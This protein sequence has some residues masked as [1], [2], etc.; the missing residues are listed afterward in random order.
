MLCYTA[1][2]VLCGSLLAAWK[3]SSAHDDAA[4]SVASLAAVCLT[5]E[6][7]L[8]SCSND[9]VRYYHVCFPDARKAPAQEELMFLPIAPER[10]HTPPP[11]PSAAAA[12]A[13]AT[14][15]TNAPGGAPSA[16]AARE[17][18]AP[19]ARPPSMDVASMEAAQ[20]QC[21]EVPC[22]ARAPAA[23]SPRRPSV[24]SPD[25]V[26]VGADF[27]DLSSYEAPLAATA[28]RARMSPLNME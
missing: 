23:S 5:S 10:C 17:G 3:F 14:P 20:Q 15:P 28:K 18:G 19:L 27:A 1:A 8:K 26:L 6:E 16:K 21:E 4:A 9:L 25:T 2:E 24:E 7:R 13:A 11:A 22:E 12:A